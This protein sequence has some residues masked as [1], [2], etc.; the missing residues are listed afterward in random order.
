MTYEDIVELARTDEA[1]LGLVLTGSRATGLGVTDDSDWDVRLIVRDEAHEECR[2]RFGT[3]HGS[4]VEVVVLSETELALAGELDTSSFWDRY[5]WVHAHVVVDR[6]AVADVVARK[7]ALPANEARTLASAA[8]DDYVN[9][10]FRSLKNDA[11]AIVEGARLDA[12]ESVSSLLDF[13]FA[14]HDRVRPFNK[15]LRWELEANPLPESTW[16]ADSLLPRLMA[17]VDTASVGEQCRL[18]CDVEGL[19]R[20]RGLGGVIDGWEPDVAWLRGW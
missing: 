12:A 11:A 16:S 14:A 18:F 13:L 20:A 10:M 6:G 8:L 19:A 9:W 5:S 1:I 2:S 7:R 4:K 3:P 15:Q 17:I